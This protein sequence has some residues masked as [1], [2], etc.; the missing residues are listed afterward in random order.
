M[1]R[2]R[3]HGKGRASDNP[4]YGTWRMMLRRCKQNKNYSHV[5]IYEPWLEQSSHGSWQW[6][7]GFERFLYWAEANLGLRPEGYSLD[8]IDCY[9]NY[10]PGNLRWANAKTQQNNRRPYEWSPSDKQKQSISKAQR[11]R[12]RKF[13]ESRGT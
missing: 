10:E 2:E 11:E 5:S 8:R 6:A 4:Y 7:P 3:K 1:N 12:W 9:G 13:R